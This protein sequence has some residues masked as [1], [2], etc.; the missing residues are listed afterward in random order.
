[1]P[2]D[3]LEG[4]RAGD[5]GTCPLLEFFTA[6]K[7]LQ[8]EGGAGRRPRHD[9]CIKNGALPVLDGPG[10]EAGRGGMERCLPGRSPLTIFSDRYKLFRGKTLRRI[11]RFLGRLFSSRP[12]ARSDV[13]ALV[14]LPNWQK[15]W[16]GERVETLSLA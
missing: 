8:P 6:A 5:N 14:H 13:T 16:P 2:S 4:E 15:S 9:I 7:I 11:S 12:D 3:H 10:R 1:M